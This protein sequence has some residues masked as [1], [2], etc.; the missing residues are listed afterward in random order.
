[1]IE[2]VAVAVNGVAIVMNQELGA[3]DAAGSQCGPRVRF[4]GSCA[5]SI[6]DLSDMNELDRHA[7]AFGAALL[8]HQA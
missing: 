5:G 7:N 1:M 4:A 8:M 2:A 6:E 3:R